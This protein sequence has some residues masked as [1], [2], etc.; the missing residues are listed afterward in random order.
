MT[1][2]VKEETDLYDDAPRHLAEALKAVAP[3]GVSMADLVEHYDLPKPNNMTEIRSDVKR[4][5]GDR[6]DVSEMKERLI[7]EAVDGINLA[8]DEPIILYDEDMDAYRFA[9]GVDP[10]SLVDS[11]G[12]PLIRGRVLPDLFNAETGVWRENM[13]TPNPEGFKG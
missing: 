12:E 1:A 8:A 6:P 2:A 5:E 13:R 11:R 9:D 10:D 3:D 7:G 4:A